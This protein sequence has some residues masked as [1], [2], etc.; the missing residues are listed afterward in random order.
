MSGASEGERGNAYRAIR[1]FAISCS[2]RTVHPAY[3]HNRRAPLLR[4]SGSNM[5][6]R[7]RDSRANTPATMRGRSIGPKPRLTNVGS[8]IAAC[9]PISWGSAAYRVAMESFAAQIEFDV[10][11]DS[12]R[13]DYR[14]TRASMCRRVGPADTAATA[15][16]ASR[17]PTPPPD[18]GG[19]ASR[20]SCRRRHPGRRGGWRRARPGSAWG[21]ADLTG[22]GGDR[23]Q[24]TREDR[25]EH[26]VDIGHRPT[27]LPQQMRIGLPIVL[28]G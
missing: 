21:R 1:R 13:V 15:T 4:W 8:A 18:A 3:S 6:R 12:G 7:Q 16:T 26:L 22:V 20:T 25:L 2:P 17:T 27:S 24:L 10:T 28:L 23:R 9:S 19:S 11:E 14:R 5:I